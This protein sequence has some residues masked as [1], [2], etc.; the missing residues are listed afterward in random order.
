MNYVFLFADV[1][2][3]L[4]VYEVNIMFKTSARLATLKSQP[5]PLSTENTL[6]Q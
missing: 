5:S 6:Q 3:I 4:V 1:I 2:S